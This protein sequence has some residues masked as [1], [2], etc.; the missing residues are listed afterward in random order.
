MLVLNNTPFVH[1]R[2]YLQYLNNALPGT[3]R[4]F[5]LQQMDAITPR[6]R[7]SPIATIPIH[8]SHFHAPWNPDA[9]PTIKFEKIVHRKP[10]TLTADHK[11]KKR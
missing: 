11:N 8:Q 9:L 4:D 5:K 6:H 7:L 2:V 1:A 3:R 10:T